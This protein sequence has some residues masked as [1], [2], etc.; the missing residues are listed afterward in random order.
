MKKTLSF[1]AVV[2]LFFAGLHIVF[3][4]PPL[5]E[6]LTLAFEEG[7]LDEAQS[8][9]ANE[10]SSLSKE[11]YALDEGYLLRARGQLNRSTQALEK[12]AELASGGQDRLLLM[13]IILNQ[14][15][16][17]TLQQDPDNLE[18]AIIALREIPGDTDDWIPL[19]S[20]AEAFLTDNPSQAIRLWQH[21]LP[22][23]YFSAWMEK[24]FSKIV[25]HNWR[26][27]QV[28][29]ARIMQ[30][31]YSEARQ[32]LEETL[33]RATVEKKG[34]VYSLIGSSYLQEGSENLPNAQ[35][36]YDK[37][38]LSYYDRLP[39]HAFKEVKPQLT[40][41]MLQQSLK[42]LERRD[43]K[44]LRF[45]VI[46]LKSWKEEI[47][48]D[49]ICRAVSQAV[50][51]GDTKLTPLLA[52]ILSEGEEKNLLIQYFEEQVLEDLEGG[53]PAV[54]KKHWDQAKLLSHAATAFLPMIQEK[55]SEIYATGLQQRSNKAVIAIR[56]AQYFS[57][58]PLIQENQMIA[59]QADDESRTLFRQGKYLKALREAEWALM[60]SPKVAKANEI[61]ALSLYQLGENRLALGKLRQVR[62]KTLLTEEALAVTEIL[63]GDAEK[64]KELLE[65]INQKS[66]EIYDR[67]GYGMLSEGQLEEAKAWFAKTKTPPKAALCYIAYSQGEWAKA[68]E[69]YKKLPK[70]YQTLEGCQGIAALSFLSTH[71]VDEAKATIR[72]MLDTKHSPSFDGFSRPF[73][74]FKRGVL[75]RISINYVV[76]VFFKK[77][78]GENLKALTYF[79][80]AKKL[81]P[82]GVIE[83]ADT[84]I[85]LGMA[86]QALKCLE[87][88]VEKGKVLPLIAEAERM[89]GNI[90]EAYAAYQGYTTLYP[91]ATTYSSTYAQILQQVHRYDLA[92]E[93]YAKLQNVGGWSS[94]DDVGCLRCLVYTN[95][96]HDADHAAQQWLQVNKTPTIKELAEVALLMN[97]TSNKNVLVPLMQK[98]EKAQPKKTADWAALLTLWS[99]LGEDQ[100]AQTVVKQKK[101]EL[102]TD[103]A[104]LLALSKYYLR[105][106]DLKKASLFAEKAFRERPEDP[107]IL[108]YLMGN[109]PLL[110]LLRSYPKEG[111]TPSQTIHLLLSLQEAQQTEEVFDFFQL[112]WTAN[113][114][115]ELY[116]E[117]PEYS[118][119]LGKINALLGKK[120]MAKKAFE[121]SLKQDLSSKQ[122]AEAL[123]QLLPPMRAAETIKTALHTHPRDPALWTAY[124]RY[125]IAAEFYLDAIEAL[126]RV[127]V[128]APRHLEPRILLGKLYLNL[129]IPEEAQSIFEEALKIDPNNAEAQHLLKQALPSKREE[130]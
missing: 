58:K 42:A 128:L 56:A 77:V 38:A 6:R 126:R 78:L 68:L 3:S 72:K 89:L 35:I 60:L 115:A 40:E 110:N 75:D 113:H 81:P 69:I 96:F 74:L 27:I 118:Y 107:K 116:P 109:P 21:P 50:L 103:N 85:Q 5:Q 95:Q 11:R 104:G 44:A 123:A 22:R 84:L 61:I 88:A 23:R 53:Q 48:L 10:G 102:K 67:I 100:R 129:N 25:T 17:A 79:D 47:A 12:A 66:D 29:K 14:A 90:P 15:L 111:T 83:K 49:T 57:L 39:P 4:A 70:Q 108:A 26:Q 120:E 18:K 34:E 9:L 80:K 106:S 46:L 33:R 43:L 28:A 52:K 63:A 37:L 121:K 1:L 86:K 8:L 122:A 19:F 20:G 82:G 7:K 62:P 41:K 13:E 64:G 31:E 24:V 124:S 55:V 51:A 16:N 73:F 71:Q 54:A 125:L 130:R 127:I 76:G 101:T 117:L 36:G 97:I 112:E 98:L 93:E 59:M 92:L 87:E 32:L 99:E 119:L 45:Y 91:E 94:K 105:R 65:K 30:G 114:L 2:A